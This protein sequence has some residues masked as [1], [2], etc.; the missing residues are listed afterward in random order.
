HRI[1][2]MLRRDGGLRFVAVDGLHFDMAPARHMLVSRHTDQ[3]GMIGRVGTVLGAHNINIA[4]MHLGRATARGEA[5][6]VMQLDDLLTAEALDQLQTSLGI[7]E[8]RAV[9]LPQAGT[10]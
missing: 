10:V 9:T 6:M 1:A 3:P 7:I 2:G 4:G 5:I 8:V